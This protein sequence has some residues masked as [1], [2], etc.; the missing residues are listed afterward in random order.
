MNFR[1]KIGLE[2]MSQVSKNVSQ[3]ESVNITEVE[4]FICSQEDAFDIHQNPRKIEQ[5][6]G[7]AVLL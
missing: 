3:T 5:I 6:T 7:I 1:L 4:E 2:V